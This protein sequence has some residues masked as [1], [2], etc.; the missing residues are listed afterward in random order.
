MSKKKIT[1][2]YEAN[3]HLYTLLDVLI[4]LQEN[5]RK[6]WYPD[7]INETINDLI[8]KTEN[9]IYPGH[10]EDDIADEKIISEITYEINEKD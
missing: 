10:E 5:G 1:E 3:I 2:T 9:H 6:C 4:A 8:K 7:D